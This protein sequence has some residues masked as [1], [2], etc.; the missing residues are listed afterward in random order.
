MFAEDEELC[1][2]LDWDSKFFDRR[3]G[4]T[5]LQRLSPDLA[6]RITGWC[7]LHAIECC[8]LLANADDQVSLRIAQKHRFALVDVASWGEYGAARSRRS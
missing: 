8:Y 4:R 3:I 2:Y 5:N 1:Q 7:A 6:E